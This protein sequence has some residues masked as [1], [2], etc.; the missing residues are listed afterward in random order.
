MWVYDPTVS[1]NNVLLRH[2]ST[3]VALY[4]YDFSTSETLSV[5]R[6]P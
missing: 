2:W 4:E 3:S 5:V 1:Q 6:L